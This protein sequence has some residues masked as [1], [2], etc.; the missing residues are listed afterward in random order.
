MQ[1]RDRSFQRIS[2]PIRARVLA[3]I[4]IPER[5]L[6]LGAIL[7]VSSV[8]VA[9]A[10]V[11]IQYLQIDALTSLLVSPPE[12][13]LVSGAPPLGRHC[14]SDYLMPVELGLRP[15]PWE[16]YPVVMPGF[17]GRPFMNNYPP[18]AML[19]QL[20]FGLLGYAVGSPAFGM[21]CYVAALTAAVLAPAAWAANGTAGLERIV[22]FVACGVAAIPAWAAVDRANS[23][24]FFAPIG[25]VFLLA[26]T[27]QRWGLVAVM[28][29][30]A[31]LLKPQL[32]VL[33][34]ALF[35]LR[36]WRAA[37]ASLGGV[38]LAELFCYL[39]WP[40]DFPQTITQSIQGVLSTGNTAHIFSNANVALGNPLIAI[41]HAISSI[42]KGGTPD[43]FPALVHSATSYGLLLTISAL[44][45]IFG[46]RFPPVMIGIVLLATASLFP[47]VSNRY[48]LVFA[49]PI[50][51]VV[52]R[53]P[54]DKHG[55]GLFEQMQN[56]GTYR[57]GAAI[58]VTIAAALTI[59]QVAIPGP[60]FAVP[61][62][63]V[64]GTIIGYTDIVI[65]TAHLT[66]LLWLIA[67]ATVLFSYVR[68]SARNQFI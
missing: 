53:A 57:R 28:V 29:I 12:D 7:I 52:A 67:C 22:V 32:I 42:L 14:F 36:K 51:A 18:A 24:G 25:L 10:F 5:T 1:A 30:L 55:V 61:Q 44:L 2:D 56:L 16:P 26:L 3:I 59:A 35:A 19:P 27:R 45:V 33:V 15:N 34:V 60:S 48:Y 58:T 6:M 41:P 50:A 37:L 4:A 66:S 49:I 8:S 39:L 21:F 43:A 64:N 11:L 40:R 31:A 13:C 46:R 54:D 63:G 68:H 65:S 9:T 17:D 62:P 38:V 20:V 23:I 47:A